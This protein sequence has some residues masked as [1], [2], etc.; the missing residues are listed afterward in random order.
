MRP[1]SSVS[2]PLPLEP[3]RVSSVSTPLPLELRRVSS[4]NCVLSAQSVHHYLLNCVLSAQ[5]VRHYLLN[6][7]VSAQ[8]VRDN[9]LNCVLSAQSTASCQLSQLRPVSSVSTPLPLR[10]SK[11]V[12]AVSRSFATAHV[13]SVPTTDSVPLTEL[14]SKSHTGDPGSRCS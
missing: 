11:L 14:L 13:T 6:C 10:S 1:V 5:S 4:V 12:S 3:R 8:S 9:L 7:V 2:T